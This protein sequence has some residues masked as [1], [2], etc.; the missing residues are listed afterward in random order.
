[1]DEFKL[2]DNE[3]H[4]NEINVSDETSE[5]DEFKIL[6]DDKILR[7]KDVE[8][9]YKN[10]NDLKTLNILPKNN[11]QI[12]IVTHK[13]FS[14]IDFISMISN[15]ENIIE[16]NLAIYRINLKSLSVLIMLHKKHKF[17]MNIVVSNF[18]RASKKNERWHTELK[19]YAEKNDDVTNFHC[20]THAKISLVKTENN[21][22]VIEGS[23]NMSSNSR[24]EQ[25]IFENNKEVFDFHSKWIKELS[26]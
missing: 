21:Y 8:K 25:Y 18:F 7:K 9:L 12:R 17:K 16:L 20:D 2:Y 24:I 23:G 6:I 22:Y 15:F 5:T 11:E 1:M 3:F 26:F 13:N 14:S 4:F 19:Y 10:I